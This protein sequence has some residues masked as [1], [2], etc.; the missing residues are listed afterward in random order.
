M[1]HDGVI[2]PSY[3]GK[4]RNNNLSVTLVSKYY[5]TIVCDIFQGMDSVKQISNHLYKKVKFVYDFSSLYY[6]FPDKK[7]TLLYTNNVFTYINQLFIDRLF[8]D[9]EIYLSYFSAH[10]DNINS[11]LTLLGVQSLETDYEKYL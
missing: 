5:D 6:F 2:D 9:S 8:N 3:D 11:L 4:T 7:S 10:D 1:I